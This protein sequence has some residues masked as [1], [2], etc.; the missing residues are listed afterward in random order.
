MDLPKPLTAVDYANLRMLAA[1]AS[2]T[3][4]IRQNDAWRTICDDLY[5]RLGQLAD[6]ERRAANSEEAVATATT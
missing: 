2:G 3:P 6:S 4:N 5:L 1:I